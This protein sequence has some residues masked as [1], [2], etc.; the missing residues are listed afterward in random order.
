MSDKRILFLIGKH[1]P[2]IA[3]L[4][5]NSTR[6]ES[7]SILFSTKGKGEGTDCVRFMKEENSFYQPLF[8][9]TK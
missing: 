4:V 3:F 1:N 6:G 5:K 8:I 9:E 2:I 7:R